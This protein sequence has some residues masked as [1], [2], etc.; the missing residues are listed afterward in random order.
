MRITLKQWL[1]TN[2]NKHKADARPTVINVFDTEYMQGVTIN[3]GS[4]LEQILV[5]RPIVKFL[6][7]YVVSVELSGDRFETA[8]NV[9][10]TDSEIE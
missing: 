7:F 6:D 2:Y 1:E 5:D 3:V 4:P 9:G 8:V 10:V